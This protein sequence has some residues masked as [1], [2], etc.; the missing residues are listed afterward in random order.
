MMI[1]AI[2][3][4]THAADYPNDPTSVEGPQGTN[5]TQPSSLQSSVSL[6]YKGNRTWG[7]SLQ[8]ADQRLNLLGFSVVE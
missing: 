1:Y 2:F 7:A 8:D 5:D 4:R 3:T 6:L